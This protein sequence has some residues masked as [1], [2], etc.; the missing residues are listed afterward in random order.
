MDIIKD[1]EEK[2]ENENEIRL[3]FFNLTFEIKGGSKKCNMYNCCPS[4]GKKKCYNY[5]P[6]KLSGN[7]KSESVCQ[8]F[9]PGNNSRIYPSKAIQ[10]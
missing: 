5:L 4:R 6:R 7:I 3:I 9:I 8:K 2:K 10:L 1:I